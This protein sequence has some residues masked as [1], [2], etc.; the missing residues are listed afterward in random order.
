[1][2]SPLKVSARNLLA[3]AG[4]AALW[5]WSLAVLLGTGIGYD[6][7]IDS[8]F[9][10]GVLTSLWRIAKALFLGSTAWGVSHFILEHFDQGKTNRQH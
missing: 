4:A 6:H 7:P 10:G 3:V 9:G 8:L 2:N 1:M 5:L